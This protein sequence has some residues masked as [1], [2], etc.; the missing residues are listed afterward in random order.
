[1]TLRRTT[2][3][4]Q[5]VRGI[6]ARW[7][8][9]VCLLSSENRPW[10]AGFRFALGLSGAPLSKFGGRNALSAGDSVLLSGGGMLCLAVRRG[11][12]RQP[13]G[14]MGDSPPVFVAFA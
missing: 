13:P 7:T 8:R 1:V 6:F 12:A 11:D 10:S 9:S 2:V 5:A 14:L 4:A 3:A